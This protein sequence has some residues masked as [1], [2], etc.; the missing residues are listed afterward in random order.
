MKFNLPHSWGLTPR[1]AIDLQKEL[2]GRIKLENGV[3]EVSLV[4]GADVHFP[5]KGRT[6]AAVALLS[7]PDLALVESRVVEGEVSFPYVPGL[8][9]FREAPILLEAFSGLSKDPDLVLLDGQGLA[10]PRRMGLACHMG[11][12][13]GVP[14]IGCAKSRLCGE[15][16][17]PDIERGSWTELVDNGEVIGSVLRTRDGVKPLYVSPGYLVDFEAARKWTLEC[18][19]GYRLPEPT[20][21]AHQIAGG[22]LKGVVTKAS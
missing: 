9:A 22:H 12:Y 13:L 14:T 19:R 15:H 4:A 8:L 17:E 21:L 20:R 1:E 5:E 2:A 11:L 10:H 6:R 18:C 7:Y 3:K 16:P